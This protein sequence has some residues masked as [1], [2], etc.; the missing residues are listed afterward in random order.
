MS[1]VS[2]K[3]RFAP[4][5]TGAM[6]VGNL[7]TAVLNW[8]LARAHGGE[9][10]VRIED[11]D[12]ER[13]SA[14]HEAGLLADLAWLGLEPDQPP[15]RQS[16]RDAVYQRHYQQ[17]EAG[18]RVYPCFCTAEELALSRAAQ[19]ASGRPPR[20]AGT[21]AGLDAAGRAARLAAG[22]QPTLRFRVPAGRTVE[23]VDRIRG[24]Q[25]FASDD[26]GDFII[27]RADGSP[28]FFFCNAVD[29]ACQGISHVVRGEDHLAN[30]PRQLLLLEALGLSAPEYAHASTILGDDGAPLSKRNGSRSV[31]ELR[32]EGMLPLAVLNYLARLGHVMDDEG[33][34][35]PS[36]LAAGFSLARLGRS[37]GHYDAGQLRHWQRLAVSALQA[38]ALH[39]WVAG[40]G[41]AVPA[42]PERCA[43]FA[44]LIQPNVL[45]H[46]EVRDWARV[47]YGAPDV[48]DDEAR[49]LCRAAGAGF[50]GCA[51]A[52]AEQGWA[53]V[54]EQ[55][56]SQTGARGKL[57]FMPLRIAL[58]GRRYGPE[59]PA[60]AAV[61][62]PAETRLR[63][64]QA[65]AWC[66]DAS[67]G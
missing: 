44:V 55:V 11:T 5:P 13:S 30:T 40:A 50:F 62:G 42:E 37:A 53:A 57:L 9:F 66:A 39:A 33:L 49:A 47:V 24:P 38:E 31:A 51:A 43:A 12:R 61:L 46:A 67:G 35:E 16:E 29:D 27:R 52:A 19:R 41:G 59:L 10:L 34:L 32:G 58:T 3:T 4:S 60:L 54:L 15:L 64:Q 22:R 21:C 2:V 8:L 45:D 26:I 25:S 1:K 7:R 56:R 28:A 6:H 14:V 17:L 36:A 48:P 20:Y 23:F 63:L 18:E 65:A